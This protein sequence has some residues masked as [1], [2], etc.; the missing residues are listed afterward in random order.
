MYGIEAINANNGWAISVVGISIVFTGLV[1]LSLVISQLHKAIELFE[2][3]EKIKG[4]FSSPTPPS[5]PPT[6]R[7]EAALVLSISQMEAARHFALL[8]NT[9][10]DHFSLPHLLRLAESR[11]IESP[12][13]NL[14]RLIQSGILYPDMDGWFCWD[15]DRF[16]KIVSH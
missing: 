4:F 12:H 15:A 6:E 11:G 2:N 3:P 14:N 10:D 13:A 8:V 5:V 16:N 1:V 7:D 9:L